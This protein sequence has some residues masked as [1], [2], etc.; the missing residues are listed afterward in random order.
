MLCAINKENKRINNINDFIDTDVKECRIVLKFQ[1]EEQ[2]PAQYTQQYKEHEYIF[3][4]NIRVADYVKIR[5]YLVL[6]SSIG[7]DENDN[8]AV[9]YTDKYKVASLGLFYWFNVLRKK[10][11]VENMNPFILDKEI[12]KIKL[13]NIYV[14]YK[15]FCIDCIEVD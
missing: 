14:Y 1:L 3:V 7:I 8:I 2:G 4:D 10:I 12:K 6:L 9:T 5:Y 11:G 13:T 15:D